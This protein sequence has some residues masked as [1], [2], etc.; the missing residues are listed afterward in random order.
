M[1]A[2]DL[3]KCQPG[4]LLE[5][6]LNEPAIYLGGSGCNNFPHIVRSKRLGTHTVNNSGSCYG[7]ECE[8]EADV[9]SIIHPTRAEL[10]EQR[11]ELLAACKSALAALSQPMTYPAD[12]ELAK[13][14]MSCAIASAEATHE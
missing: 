13:A 6:R 4:D 10:E 5:M 12:I 7:G 14:R 9:I 8:C 2:V 3:T 11:R 1:S